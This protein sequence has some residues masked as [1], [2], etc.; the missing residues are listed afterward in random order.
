M[1]RILASGVAHLSFPGGGIFLPARNP[2]DR[3][4]LAEHVAH[5]ARNGGQVQVLV[6]SERWMVSLNSYR[7]TRHCAV[8]GSLSDLSCYS[9]DTDRVSFCLTCAF[10]DH[11][12]P[13][14]P[15]TAPAAGEEQETTP[16]TRRF[17][18]DA[19]AH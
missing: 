4:L 15:S 11:L 13:L 6:N 19:V 10:S 14:L 3:Q 18:R 2:Y 7:E 8:C 12:K 5:R 9:P 16:G 1:K 17:A